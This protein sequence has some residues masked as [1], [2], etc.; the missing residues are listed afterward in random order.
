MRTRPVHWSEGML[1]LPHHFQAASAYQSEQLTVSQ[2]WQCPCNY[3]VRAMD[4]DRDAL[5]NFEVRIPR[6]QARMRDGSLLLV[7][8]NA[9]LDILD[10]RPEMSDGQDVYLHL[11][12]PEIVQGKCNAGRKGRGN[13]ERFLIEAEEWEDRNA[14]GNP[15]PIETHRFNARVV[16][17]PTLESPKGFESL[18]IGRLQRSQQADSPPQLAEDYIP[19]LLCCDCWPALRDGILG[20]VRAQLGS[21]TKMQADY[22]RT[23]GG[24]TEANQPQIRKGIAQLNAVNSSYPYL[25]QLTEALGV[26]PFLA[27]TELCRL[28]GQL[29]LFRDDWQPPDLPIYDHDDLGRIFRAIKIELDVIFRAEG[30]TA[31]VQRYPFVGVQEWMEVALDPRWLRGNYGLY[32]G[33]RSELTAERLELLFSDRWLDWKLGSSRTILQIYRNAEAG[34]TLNRVAGVHQSLPA[35]KNVTYFE[36]D[37]RGRY[38]EQSAESR[39]LALKVNERYIRGDFIGQST[40]TVIDPR[41]NPRDLTLELFVVENE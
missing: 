24:W 1:V 16:A 4:L 33:V 22:L 35:L 2:N 13:D 38:W 34:L 20:A 8:E 37:L 3:G 23:H 36:I 12:V 11:V 40:L 9:H 17:L 7:P 41:N 30:P 31:K 14:A 25:V 15:R 29:S 39:T 19:P 5:N 27:Y 26:H 28:V 18:P 10:L 32:V 6:L 21:Y